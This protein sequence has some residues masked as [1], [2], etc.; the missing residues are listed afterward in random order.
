[1]ILVNNLHV[2]GENVLTGIAT[3]MGEHKDIHDL[4]AALSA[5]IRR[6]AVH[7]DEIV[8]N[9]GVKFDSDGIILSYDNVPRAPGNSVAQPME[10]HVSARHAADI[11]PEQIVIES[12]SYDQIVERYNVSLRTAQRRMQGIAPSIT[13]ERKPRFWIADVLSEFQGVSAIQHAKPVDLDAQQDIN[14]IAHNCG[15]TPARL[16][17]A[18]KALIQ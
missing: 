13:V 12:W 3:I 5:Y 1:M 18:I 9:S 2:F 15:M 16:C 14:T 4:K 6:Q 11:S 10:P 8:S 17:I 7:L